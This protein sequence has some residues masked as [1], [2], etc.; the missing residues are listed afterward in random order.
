VSRDG[1]KKPFFAAFTAGAKALHGFL[2]LYGTFC[3]VTGIKNV[4]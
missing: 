2:H 3:P 1:S 4:G